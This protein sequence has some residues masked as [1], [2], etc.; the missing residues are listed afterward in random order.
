M[1]TLPN[2]CR[3][4][5]FKVFPANW[6]S[7]KAKLTDIWYA[8]CRFIDPAH[9]DKYPK[10][11][12]IRLK[13]GINRLPTVGERKEA[14]EMII[15]DM[16]EYLNSGFNPIT[17][18][19]V[20]IAPVVIDDDKPLK[21]V[22]ST[23][24]FIKAFRFALDKSENVKETKE[25]MASAIRTIER[26]AKSLG[27]IT[28]TIGEI[29]VHH[30]KILLD[31]CVQSNETFGA[32]RFNKVKSHL[33][34]LFNILVEFGATHGNMAKAISPM[35]VEQTEPKVF[36]DADIKK[37]KDHLW[38][39]NRPFYEF[40]MIFYYS[41]GRVKELFTLRGRNVDLVEQKYKARVNKGKQHWPDRTIRNVALP[42]WKKQ[43]ENCG[44]DDFVFSKDLLPGPVMINSKQ[45]SRRWM[46]HVKKPLGIQAT[47]YKLKHVNTD[48]TL[49]AL[50]A[51]MAAGQNA[52]T[53]TKMVEEVY[54]F[55]EKKRIH[56]GLK[57]L[58]IEL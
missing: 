47:F 36:S 43:M 12:P 40:M 13:S 44:P 15:K 14:M 53:S 32:K 48:R 10:G 5:E 42:L 26:A 18:N 35:K 58:D 27:F 51:K 30:I 20:P 41:G 33:S 16:E 23:T 8:Q 11:K 39:W 6:K 19:E 49:I 45:V 57:E 55:N 9:L 17:D 2:G 31:E 7:A 29:Q 38:K 25:D 54:A 52:H 24:P 1:I 21:I 50:G 37:I 22:V 3:R 4:G 34:S 56:E 28:M 46:L